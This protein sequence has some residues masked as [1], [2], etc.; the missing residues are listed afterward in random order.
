MMKTA[1]IQITDFL[2]RGSKGEILLKKIAATGLVM[3]F[4]YR[5]FYVAGVAIG[6]MIF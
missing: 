2:N 1:K 3:L 5:I 6:H 4:I